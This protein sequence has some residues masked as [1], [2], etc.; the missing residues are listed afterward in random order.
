MTG[1][2]I[3]ARQSSTVPPTAAEHLGLAERFSS[4]TD[5]ARYTSSLP[6]TAAATLDVARF[7]A[8]TGELTF[9]V[10]PAVRLYLDGG[11]VYHAERHGDPAVSA[12]L[13][14]AGVIDSVQLLRGVV[15][16]GDAEHL[17]RLFDRDATVDRDAV[18]VVLEARTDALVQQ[19][20]NSM[21]AAVSAISYRHHPSGIHRWFVAPVERTAARRPASGVMQIDRSVVDEL[22]RL[23]GSAESGGAR[24]DSARADVTIEWAEPDLSRPDSTGDA[25]DEPPHRAAA[26]VD[27]QAELDRFDADRADW[28]ATS[29]GND[30]DPSDVVSSPVGEFRIIWPDGTRDPSIVDASASTPTPAPPALPAPTGPPALGFTIEPLQIDRLPEPNAPVPEEVSAAVRRALEALGSETP[31]ATNTRLPDVDFTSL[32][33]PNSSVPSNTDD[34]LLQHAPQVDTP[35]APNPPA[36]NPPAPNPP[37]SIQP[38]ASQPPPLPPAPASA[39]TSSPA[40]APLGFAPPTMD[41]RAEVVYERASARAPHD[42]ALEA[43]PVVVVDAQTPLVPSGHAPIQDVPTGGVPIRDAPSEPEPQH[44][45]TAHPEAVSAAPVLD[46]VDMSKQRQSALRRL[47]RSLRSND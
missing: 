7:H 44:T 28:A 2:P 11:V 9:S 35:P 29:G 22:P 43:E 12:G 17:G 15:S 24:E 33:T 34:P 47:I 6:Q 10:E 23:G 41:M 39:D 26:D 18:M 27:I 40:V 25:G 21:I 16:V 37:A 14:D 20:A 36:P 5:Y 8:F 45:D 19:I 32:E 42:L 4:F 31:R 1:E 46:D 3:S 30:P 38:A 13:I